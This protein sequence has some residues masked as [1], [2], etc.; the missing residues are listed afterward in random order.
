MHE[1]LVADINVVLDNLAR[2]CGCSSSPELFNQMAPQ[3]LEGF[4]DDYTSWTLHSIGYRRFKTLATVAG[5]CL[6][7]NL[8]LVIDIFTANTS[9]DKDMECELMRGVGEMLLILLSFIP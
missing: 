4:K 1:G 2:Q 6:A 9:V 3:L 5:F 7:Q 8:Q